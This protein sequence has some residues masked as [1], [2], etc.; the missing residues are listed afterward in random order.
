MKITSRNGCV[1]LLFRPSNCRMQRERG[2]RYASC[3]DW[4]TEKPWRPYIPEEKRELRA[5]R[6]PRRQ[7]RSLDYAWQCAEAERLQEENDWLHEQ[8][9]RVNEDLWAER[10]LSDAENR[11]LREQVQQLQQQLS[12]AE[13]R[14]AAAE[15]TAALPR[16]P[17][18]ST[19]PTP[20][21]APAPA[22]DEDEEQGRAEKECHAKAN[23]QEKKRREKEQRREAEEQRRMA[24]GHEDITEAEQAKRE[25]EAAHAAIER[26]KKWLR[27]AQQRVVE[28]ND[29]RAREALQ[30]AKERKEHAQREAQVA[31][32]QAKDA[33][34]MRR[35]AER[36]VR[37]ASREAAKAAA[38][39]EAPSQQLADAALEAKTPVRAGESER[40]IDALIDRHAEQLLRREAPLRQIT[41]AQQLDKRG[42]LDRCGSQ[43]DK[44]VPSVDVAASSRREALARLRVEV[45]EADG[46]PVKDQVSLPFSESSSDPF[47][48]VCVGRQRWSTSVKQ[49]ELNPTWGGEAASFAISERDALLQVIVLDYNSLNKHAFMGLVLLP[50]RKIASDLRRAESSSDAPSAPPTDGATECEDDRVLDQ[51]FKLRQPQAIREGASGWVRLR[52]E[53]VPAAGRSATQ[54]SGDFPSA[55]KEGDDES[56][57]KHVSALAETAL[58]HEEARHGAKHAW[59]FKTA[60]GLKLFPPGGGRDVWSGVHRDRWCGELTV[61]VLRAF[62]LAALDKP[63]RGELQ[64]TSDAFVD[65]H[66][67]DMY[68]RT[69][70]V[71]QTCHPV[72][73]V[74]GA[75]A[76]EV[77]PLLSESWAASSLHL[78]LFDHNSL[79]GADSLAQNSY[80]GECLVPL[81][82]LPTDGQPATYTL[83]VQSPPYLNTRV[84]GRLELRLQLRLFETYAALAALPLLEHT[85]PPQWRRW[86]K[87]DSL[88]LVE[89]EGAPAAEQIIQ[90]RTRPANET[91]VQVTW[92]GGAPPRDERATLRAPEHEL[93]L[94]VVGA[95]DLAPADLNQTSD[96]YVECAVWTPESPQCRHVWRTR[97]KLNTLSPQWDETQRFPLD[98]AGS[99]RALLHV[100]VFDW[101]RVGEDDRIGEALISLPLGEGS[102]GGG[103]GGSSSTRA[104]KARLTSLCAP[105]DEKVAP[106]G[107]VHL[108]LT[109]RAIFA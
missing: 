44:S 26:D 18:P 72:W 2:W 42:W 46:L 92:E 48:V 55:R 85:E 66:L 63:N 84:Q 20:E 10:E 29:Q 99:N 73:G 81:S 28:L 94:T 8:L 32:L 11:T 86:S 4:A 33:E 65:V 14:A 40:A 56:E 91:G 22:P 16:Q 13:H 45:L 50:V 82:S 77:M 90:H 103:G 30:K 49:N 53:L 68:W 64:G 74:D 69:P 43:S 62:D 47:C 39:R 21:G 100:L 52:L 58:R 38:E 15:R 102:G 106:R 78:V 19:P 108:Q 7:H 25:V 59:E 37:L 61:Q 83:R 96:P 80:L 71:P 9:D 98:T 1:G 109:T 79:F 60:E 36:Q 23:R 6:S 97:T 88:Q 89:A 101:D 93:V 24:Q 76:T 31:L 104:L 75:T 27:A 87:W 34:A 67:G 57:A 17:A 3:G 12:Q 51:W 70:T 107:F 41:L 105:K 95:S 35:K 54:L 5:R